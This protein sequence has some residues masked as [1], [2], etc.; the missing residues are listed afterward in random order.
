MPFGKF[1]KSDEGVVGIVVAILLIGLMVSA[2]SLIQLVYVPEWMEQKESEHMDEVLAQF[3]QLKFVMDT[4]SATDQIG[5][6]IA[7]PITLG[8]KE[9]PYLMSVRAFGR[10][11]IEQ[12]SCTITIENVNNTYSYVLGGIKYSSANAYFLDQSYIY[13]TGAFITS[14][15]DGNIIT[16]KPA[17]SPKLINGSVVDISFSIINISGVGGKLSNSGYGDSSILTEFSSSNDKHIKNV[18]SITIKTQYVNAWYL[19]LEY[20]LKK[21][22]GENCDDCYK[23]DKYETSNEVI[24][25]PFY[26]TED[27]TKLNVHLKNININAQIG[28][29]WIE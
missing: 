16:I 9:M 7:T 28:P 6:P 3:A 23:L 4:Q 12:D 14:Q 21:E 10:L 13:E 20:I 29:G 27:S 11:D 25:T 19:F 17:F 5:T 22:I 18:K 2:V 26:A 24:I 1:K 8:S 15:T